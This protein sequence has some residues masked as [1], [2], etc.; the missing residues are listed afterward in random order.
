MEEVVREEGARV[1][2][3]WVVVER[4]EVEKGVGGWA[5]AGWVEVAKAVEASCSMTYISSFSYPC[6]VMGRSQNPNATYT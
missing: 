5:G 2:V 4:E 6:C 3:G 1:V